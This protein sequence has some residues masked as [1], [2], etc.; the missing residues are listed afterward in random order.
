MS[1]PEGPRKINADLRKTIEEKQAKIKAENEAKRRER[2]A[3]RWREQRDPVEYDRQKAK[4]RGDYAAQIAADEGRNVRAYTPVPG[5]T[6]AEHDKNAKA[7]DAE[8]KR[9]S[10]KNAD[11]AAKDREADRKWERRKRGAGWTDEQIIEGL[12]NLAAKRAADR[13]Y[14]QPEPVAYADNPNF[15]LF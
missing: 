8:R 14:S 6:R 4:Q 15:G 12:A 10:R 1:A 13:Y 2:N 11:Q 9:A 3:R 5:K 7:R